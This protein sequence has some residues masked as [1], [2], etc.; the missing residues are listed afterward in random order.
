MINLKEEEF[1]KLVGEALLRLPEK[2]RKMMDNVEIVIERSPTPEQ[3]REAGV[4]RGRTL[5]GLYQGVPKTR[6]GRGFGM[7]L[8]DKITIFKNSI[9]MF[10]DTKEDIKKMVNNVVWHEIAHHFGYDEKG[11][12]TMEEKRKERSR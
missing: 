8:P 11:I 3:T 12:S 9:E 4:R 10:A 1:E 7:I 2:I 6:W 5:L